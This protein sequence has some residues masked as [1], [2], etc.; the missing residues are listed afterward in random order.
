ML[1]RSCSCLHCSHLQNFGPSLALTRSLT[2]SHLTL[3]TAG[4]KGGRI[5]VSLLLLLLLLLALLALL[6]AAVAA[7]F[8]PV[9]A[10]IVFVLP[11]AAAEAAE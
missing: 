4:K 5:A 8:S 3:R 7:N 6:A 2:G 11:S 1:C 9:F 10:V